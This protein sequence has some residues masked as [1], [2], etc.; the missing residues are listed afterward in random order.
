M[1]NRYYKYN[2]PPLMNDGRFLT[3][4]VRSRVF[5]Q[6]VRNI[7]NVQSSQEYRHFLQNNGDQILNNLK[8]YL[9]ES[10]TCKIE[11]KCLPMSG[12][13][14]DDVINYLKSNDRVSSTFFNQLND[15]K[16]N[17]PV[18]NNMFFENNSNTQ[19]VEDLSAQK[20]QEMAKNIY[21]KMVYEQQ[22]KS[23]SDMNK[24]RPSN[25]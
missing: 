5:D 14:S 25:V 2:C 10:N 13:N 1:D 17:Q 6:Y 23:I 12:P 24:I 3:S 20:A 4:Y 8:G 9:R 19:T 16:I 21:A 22:Q 7:N 18:D 11:G 15:E